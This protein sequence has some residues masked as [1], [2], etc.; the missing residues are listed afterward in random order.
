MDGSVHVLLDRDFLSFVD[1]GS[2]FFIPI[3]LDDLCLES[4]RVIVFHL[5]L[6]M[7]GEYLV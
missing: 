3:Q 7:Y 5:A 2:P 4:D 6:C 1:Q